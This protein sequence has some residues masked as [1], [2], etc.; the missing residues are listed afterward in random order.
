MSPSMVVPSLQRFFESSSSYDSI[1][2]SG[3]YLEKNRVGA[4]GLEPTACWL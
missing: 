1:K 2:E 3:V 4:A